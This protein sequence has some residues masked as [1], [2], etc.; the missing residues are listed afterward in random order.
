MLTIKKVEAQIAAQN[1]HRELFENSLSNTKTQINTIQ[2][3]FTAGQMKR[4]EN[5]NRRL[6]WSADDISNGVALHATGARAYRLLLRKQYPLPAM[7][8]LKRWCSKVPI[9]PDLIEPFFSVLSNTN[10]EPL[11]KLCV[12]SFDE[13]KIKKQFVYCKRNDETIATSKLRAGRNDQRPG[14]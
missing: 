6:N 2:T 1:R 9:K 7:S 13:M 10:T 12:L 3:I 4:L 8:T 11:E 14:G 5:P